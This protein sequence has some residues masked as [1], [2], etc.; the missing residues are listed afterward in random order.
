M[1]DQAKH[2]QANAEEKLRVSNQTVSR[3][4]EKRPASSSSLQ[5][6]ALVLENTQLKKTV[7]ELKQILNSCRTPSD[8]SANHSNVRENFCTNPSKLYCLVLG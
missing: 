5:I 4:K 7:S 6:E 3:E 1:V 2:A 8:M